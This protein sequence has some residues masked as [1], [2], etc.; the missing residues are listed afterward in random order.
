MTHLPLSTKQHIA[1]DTY[2][3]DGDTNYRKQQQQLTSHYDSVASLQIPGRYGV[4]PILSPQVP[5]YHP[6][7][8]AQRS[9]TVTPSYDNHHQKEHEIYSSI[10]VHQNI[11]KHIRNSRK[12]PATNIVHTPF[13]AKTT[14]ST[15]VRPPASVL[16]D[17]NEHQH[18]QQVKSQ[19]QN[20]FPIRSTTPQMRII[21]VR[22]SERANQALGPDWFLRAFD[23]RTGVYHPYDM[24]LPKF[25]PKRQRFQA[26]RF[27][28]PLTVRGLHL[29]RLTG[30]TMAHSN[31]ASTIC[32]TS[33]ALRCIQTCER[34]LMGMKRRERVQ[35]RVEPGLFECPHF[36][37][38]LTDSFMTPQELLDNGYRIKSDYQPIMPKVTVPET[39]E[40]YF[41][42]SRFVM[43][44]IMDRYSSPGANVLIVT[45]APGLIALTDALQGI[46]TNA[47]TFYK[48]VS[49]YDFL[50]TIIAEYDNGRWQ[51]RNHVWY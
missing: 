25:L 2:D 37:A 34:L 23:Q 41:N 19:I 13:V 40:V 27:D 24:N 30:Q 3:T 48:R 1:L 7:H 4:D 10:P 50:A 22:H 18:Q 12:I 39:L 26:F 11:R 17:A 46:K 33:S 28:P 47:D 15:M 14:L 43:K 16:H 49:K 9:V 38:H 32:L 42:R 51:L 29:A 21:F 45:H 5:S 8:N 35:I 20:L 36:N 31:L 44:G 6:F